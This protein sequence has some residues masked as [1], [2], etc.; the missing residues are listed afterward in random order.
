MSGARF[1]SK[2]NPPGKTNIGMTIARV[3]PRKTEASPTDALAFFDIQSLL[4]CKINVINPT[5]QHSFENLQ[6]GA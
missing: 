6:E 3:F 1:F 5:P 4:D 2:T